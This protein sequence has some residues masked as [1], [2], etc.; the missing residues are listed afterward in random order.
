M[1]LCK[2]S[3]KLRFGVFYRPPSSSAAFDSLCEVLFSVEQ[4]LFSNFVILGDFNV[5]FYTTNN[6]YPH[7][8]NATTSFSLTQVV[9]SPTHLTPTGQGAE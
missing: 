2:S 8:C 7:I 6:L 9:D 4:S 1:S 3:F 5:N